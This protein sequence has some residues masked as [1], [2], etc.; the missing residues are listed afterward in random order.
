MKLEQALGG[1]VIALLI[2]ACT[3]G[4]ASEKVIKPGEGKAKMEAARLEIG[5][6]RTNIF[7]TL[8]LLDQARNAETS[9]V[10]K[11][12]C[13]RFNLQFMNMIERVNVTAERARAMKQRG[14]AYFAD[15]E[16]RTAEITD[17][18]K[19]RLAQSRYKA[20]KRSFDRLVNNLQQ[21]RVNFNPM[22]TDLMQIQQLLKQ[23][24]DILKAGA[25][26]DV[27]MHANWRGMDVR[28]FLEATEVEFEF[29][30]A[31]FALYEQ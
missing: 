4:N 22:L 9:Q 16:A 13:D 6:L 28:R 3:L 26:R 1:F 19:R 23:N 18:E 12:L 7:V 31:D 20:R 5:T 15:W 27:F 8:S 25:A 11:A 2:G 29:L 30:A 21:A 17:V 14:D 10:R 24:T